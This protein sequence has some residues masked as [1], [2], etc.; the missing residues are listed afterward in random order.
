MRGKTKTIRQSE[1]EGKTDILSARDLATVPNPS[2]SRKSRGSTIRKKKKKEKKK[3]NEPNKENTW[4]HKRKKTV[5]FSP[6]A[7]KVARVAMK[8]KK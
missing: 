5:A 7:K 4:I 1:H 2:Q 3:A 6:N 8:K